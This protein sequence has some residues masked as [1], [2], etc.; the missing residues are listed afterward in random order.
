MSF[1]GF[2]RAAYRASF[3]NRLARI[4]QCVAGL[5]GVL[6]LGGVTLVIADVPTWLK[7]SGVSTPTMLSILS[8]ALVLAAI[9]T[10]HGAF[11]IWKEAAAAASQ[12]AVQTNDVSARAAL[13]VGENAGSVKIGTMRTSGF[14]QAVRA[15]GGSTEIGSMDSEAS[16][17][18]P[19]VE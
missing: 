8:V 6:S 5:A 2:L 16:R 19:R 12:S 7:T 13:Y 18:T 1:W 10:V 9:A 11:L 14:D 3:A 17:K 4:V 15:M